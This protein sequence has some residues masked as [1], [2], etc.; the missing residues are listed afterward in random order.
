VRLR[1]RVRTVTADADVE[2]G[3]VAERFDA[4]DAE[5]EG[6]AGGPPRCLDGA[7]AAHQEA[8]QGTVAVLLGGEP[9]HA[10]DDPRRVPEP[11]EVVA[12]PAERMHDVEVVD[13]EQVALAGIEEHEFP[14]REQ[15]ERAAEPRPRPSG[16]SLDP[17][18]PA[19]PPRVECPEAVA[20]RYP[21]AADHDRLGLLQSHVR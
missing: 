2:P 12:D 7:Q 3:P 10:L 14:E 11:V 20:V 13:A 18:V 1:K 4:P 5:A 15:L 16:I 19:E 21:A 8:V 9:G 17:V 6:G